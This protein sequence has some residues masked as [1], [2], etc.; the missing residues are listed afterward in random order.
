MSIYKYMPTHI[1][2]KND[3]QINIMKYIFED[4]VLWFSNPL[5]FNDPFELKPHI[6]QLTSNEKHIVVDTIQNYMNTTGQANAF[7]YLTVKSILNNIGILSLSAN[8]TH[9]AM[10]SHYANNHKGIVLEFD[11]NHWFFQK[12]I[13]P[14]EYST[15]VHHLEEVTY[16]D[17]TN[18]ESI[19]SDEYF[20]KETFLTKGEDWRYEKE[21][22]MT[23][24]VNTD[25]EYIDGIDVIFPNDLIK[26]VYIGNKADKKTIKYIK[27]LKLLDDWKHI[28]IFKM[29]LD[30]REYKLIANEITKEN[31]TI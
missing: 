12:M 18:R 8:K 30:K 27:N 4:K 15:V 25:D 26:A 9:L 16:I 28:K 3:E 11:K 21:H 5:N 7:H 31:I 19:N 24:Y 10:W 23:I 29:Q 22:R 2:N 14:P 6:K 17:N 20:K 13:L 1:Y